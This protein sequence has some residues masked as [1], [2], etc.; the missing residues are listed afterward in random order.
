M[1]YGLSFVFNTYKPSLEQ[2]NHAEWIAGKGNKRDG[3]LATQ[4]LSIPMFTSKDILVKRK[5]GEVTC[6]GNKVM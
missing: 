5:N 3:V 6:N 4:G 1:V 2:C